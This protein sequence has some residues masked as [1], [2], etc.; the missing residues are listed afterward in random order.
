MKAVAIW[1]RNDLRLHDNDT[2]N[3]AVRLVKNK[4][5][6]YV[7]PVYCYDPRYFGKYARS[8]QTGLPKT[9]IHRQRFVA[10]SLRDL[11]K[12]LRAI[13]SD[14]LIFEGRPEDVFT[15]LLP[16]GSI[17]VTQKEVTQEELDVDLLV[18]NAGFNLQTVWGLTMY[19]LSD[20]LES[21]GWGRGTE[22]SSKTEMVVDFRKYGIQP[23]QCLPTPKHGDLPFPDTLGDI[24]DSNGGATADRMKLYR[25]GRAQ[26]PFLYAETAGE[27]SVYDDAYTYEVDPRGVLGGSGLSAFGFGN[28]KPGFRG[29]ESAGLKRVSYYLPRLVGKYRTTRF[30]E[31]LGASY[32]QPLF[33]TTHPSSLAPHSLIL[34]LT[35]L[36]IAS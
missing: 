22:F 29:G 27:R 28:N 24:V 3:Q 18:K 33:L 10:E 32:P 30:R 15:R 34:T 21:R 20:I 6:S 7:L 14:L 13:G 5:A 31:M 26:Q 4:I 1:F 36:P 2:L 8:R 12:S 35:L 25:H 19:H 16:R 17:I 11:R 9:G 23:R